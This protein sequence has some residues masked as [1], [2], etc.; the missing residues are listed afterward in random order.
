MQ[1]FPPHTPYLQPATSLL[2]LLSLKSF[3]SLLRKLG[4]PQGNNKSRLFKGG[5][6]GGL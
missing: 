1:N 4:C 3:M 5:V 2:S 6:W